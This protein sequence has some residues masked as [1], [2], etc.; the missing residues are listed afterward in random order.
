[1]HANKLK[2]PIKRRLS[3]AEMC[4]WQFTFCCMKANSFFFVPHVCCTAQT[5]RG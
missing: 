5:E 4:R 2:S 3:V 1:M